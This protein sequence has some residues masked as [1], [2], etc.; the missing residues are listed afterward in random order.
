MVLY[1]D[2]FFAYSS[3]FIQSLSDLTI[4]ELFIANLRP[5]SLEEKISRLPQQK[6]SNIFTDQ[7][8]IPKTESNFL[9]SS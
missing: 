1:G 7:G 9:L 2:H 8:P 6:I 3:Y 4:L 5:A